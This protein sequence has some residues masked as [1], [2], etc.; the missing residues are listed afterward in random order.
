MNTGSSSF[1][2]GKFLAATAAA[3]GAAP[4]TIPLEAVAEGGRKLQMNDISMYVEEHASGKPV[5]LLHGWPDSANLW[6]HQVPF[7]VANGF[8][9]LT[10][11]LRGFGRSDRPADGDGCAV[12][13]SVR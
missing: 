11:D 1:S 13:N 6:R 5:L 4:V 7:L 2:R 12:G 9:V 3:V 8:R 10:P